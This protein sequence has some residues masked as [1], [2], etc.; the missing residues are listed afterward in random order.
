MHLYL[1]SGLGADYRAFERLDFPEGYKII[2]LDW[3]KPLKN[4]T[5][6]SYARRMA[7]SIDPNEDFILGG[8]SFGG[9]I[10]VEIAKFTT[11]LKLLLFSTVADRKSLPWYY[12]IAGLL[13]LDKIMPAFHPRNSLTFMFW[14][15]GPLDRDSREVLRYF[16]S[17]SD[18]SF[19][20]WALGCISRWQNESIAVPCFHIHGELDRAFPLRCIAK[21]NY[22]VKGG[23]HLVVY[24]HAKEVSKVLHDV[25]AL[26]K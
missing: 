19:I 7:A 24:T 23:G 2:H 14:F 4:E 26:E 9:I 25:L 11:P 20:L 22:V 17:N 12:P 3:I 15:F 10:A 18:S 8:L 13:R 5:L 21:V 1:I 16:I 6:Q